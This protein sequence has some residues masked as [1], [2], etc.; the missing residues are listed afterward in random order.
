M[1]ATPSCFAILAEIARFAL[2][3]LRGSARNYF[4]IVDAGESRQDFLLDTISQIGIVWIG[5]QVF[6]WKYGN[7]LWN[8]DWRFAVP[9][10]HTQT[11]CESH[12]QS[13]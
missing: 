7:A 1:F 5:T 3:G 8:Y 12:K 13:D 11:Y 6:K 9:E 2:I 10:R 4:Q